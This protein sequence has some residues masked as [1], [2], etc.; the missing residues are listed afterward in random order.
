MTVQR[1]LREEDIKL[2]QEHVCRDKKIAL[3]VM[4]SAL[5]K[6]DATAVHLSEDIT[7]A[8]KI[9]RSFNR[10]I[11]DQ[12]LAID[13]VRRDLYFSKVEAT[14]QHGNGTPEKRIYLVT[15]QRVGGALLSDEWTVLSWTAPITANLLDRQAGYEFKF[16]ADR[17]EPE[18]T[19]HI[20]GSAKY[21]RILPELVDR[22]T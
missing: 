14:V 20:E 8:P 1:R 6:S 4:G 2:V 19:F 11:R 7:G 15:K 22:F 10:F 9:A 21:G 3:E 13:T 16:Q 12:K 17:Y 18:V 5:A